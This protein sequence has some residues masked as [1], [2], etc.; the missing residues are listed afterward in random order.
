[1]YEGQC[2][3]RALD[4]AYDE[5]AGIRFTDAF[6]VMLACVNGQDAA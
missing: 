4:L 5:P 1:M 6:R 2:D 3:Q